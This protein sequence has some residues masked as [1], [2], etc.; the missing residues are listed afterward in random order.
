[1]KLRFAFNIARIVFIVAVPIV[2]LVLPADFFDGGE[3]ICLSQVLF[4]MS[5]Y[6]CGMTRACMHL[7]HFE[8]EEAYAYHMLSFLVV[9]LLAIVWVQWFLKEFKLFKKFRAMIKS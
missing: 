1:M 8:F 5:C 7:I 9:P 2:L 3:S 4:N 6:A